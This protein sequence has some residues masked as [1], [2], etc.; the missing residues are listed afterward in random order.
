MSHEFEMKI[1][2]KD[3]RV[4]NGFGKTEPIR[5]KSLLMKLNVITFFRDIDENISGISLKVNKRQ[6]YINKFIE[7]IRETAFHY[8]P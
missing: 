4:D 8:L 5:L 3:F 2:A 6:I 7:T 1:L